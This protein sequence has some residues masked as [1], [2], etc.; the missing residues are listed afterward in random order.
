M[1]PLSIIFEYIKIHT[2]E[3]N[4]DVII[5]LWKIYLF[6]IS[7]YKRKYM[8]FYKEIDKI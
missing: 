5:Y 4:F 8:K 3:N 2:D 1:P 7:V 6:I